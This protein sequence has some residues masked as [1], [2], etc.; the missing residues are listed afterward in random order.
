[1]ILSR[2]KDRVDKSLTPAAI[3]SLVKYITSY[4][5][6]NSEIL[7]SFDLSQ[8]FSF[9]D[10]DRE[11]VYTTI[12][13]TAAE[14]EAMV[15]ESK[16]IYSGNKIH[17]NPF[18]VASMIL[19]N[20]LYTNLRKEKEAKM[21]MTYMSLMMYTSAHKGFFDYGANKQIMDYTIAHLDNSFKIRTMSSLFAFLDDNAQTAF[22]TYKSRI[23][24]CDDKDITYVVDA[25]HT[26]VK[27]K[28]KKIANAYYKNWENG[29]YLN[30]DQDSYDAE[31]FHEIDNN[32]FAEDRLASKIYIRLLNHQFDDRLIKYSITNSDVSYQKLK[33]LI[34][35]IV[36]TDKTN[37]VR[38]Y[39]TNVIEYY[40][41]TSGKSYDY[42]AKGDFIAYMKSAYASNTDSEHMAYIKSTLDYWLTEHAI[43][44]GRQNYGKT[45]KQGYK[46]GLYMFFVFLINYEA[47]GV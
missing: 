18:Y 16:D 32:S 23:S 26:R 38:R 22:D 4:V 5:D 24:K 15:K 35:D 27:Q 43:T 11:I 20:R 44:I 37:E 7:M 14:M 29:N 9:G 41:S 10:P 34:D 31:D 2:V 8:R 36:Q 13:I 6:K 42:I 40:L 25:L 39:I 30:A 17:S 46:K 33:N 3:T 19:I 28:V 47:K 21:V 12:G 45:A 1:M